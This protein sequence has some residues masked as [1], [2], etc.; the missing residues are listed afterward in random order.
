M[1]TFCCCVNT[2]PPVSWFPFAGGQYL[3]VGRKS[4]SSAVFGDSP[5]L[6]ERTQS[7][8]LLDRAVVEGR[9]KRWPDEANLTVRTSAWSQTSTMGMLSHPILRKKRLLCQSPERGL[10]HEAQVVV[11]PL[12]L[13]GPGLHAPE[14]GP[15][16]RCSQPHLNRGSKTTRVWDQEASSLTIPN[17]AWK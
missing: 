11:A 13:S 6:Q 15:S 5:A 7:G 1:L 12:P 17:R 8:Q 14:A 2:G 16:G 10:Q 3:S 9:P 4:S